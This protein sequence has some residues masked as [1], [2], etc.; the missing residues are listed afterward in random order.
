[1]GENTGGRPPLEEGKRVVKRSFSIKP[2][3]LEQLLEVAREE[4]KGV[5]EVLREVLVKVFGPPTE[6]KDNKPNGAQNEPPTE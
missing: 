6:T 5:S 1:V 2:G 4:S 3:Q